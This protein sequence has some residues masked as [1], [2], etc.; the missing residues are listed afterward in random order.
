M[1]YLKA[2]GIYLLFLWSA[3]MMIFWMITLFLDM[4]E[5]FF[6]QSSSG[7]GVFWGIFIDCFVLSWIYLVMA[8]LPTPFLVYFLGK[9][10]Q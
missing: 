2:L 6:Q 7:F 1:C 10:C 8:L 3:S 9:L 5:K 4:E